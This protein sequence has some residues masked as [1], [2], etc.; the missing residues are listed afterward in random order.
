MNSNHHLLGG[1]VLSVL[2]ASSASAQVTPSEGFSLA[3]SLDLTP[4]C[5]TFP[6]V[7]A[8]PDGSTLIFDGSN[9]SRR[10]ADGTI[11][12]DYGTRPSS[13][14]ASFVRVDE[15]NGLAYIGESSFGTITEL[16]LDTGASRVLTTLGF[17][18]DL[19]FDVVPG[20]AYVTASPN[21]FGLNALYRLDLFSGV[22]TLVAQL[23]GYSGPVL[24]DSV[25]NVTVSV[26]LGQF[27][28]PADS[29]KLIQF[30]G[31]EVT[32]GAIL[33]DE[34]DGDE[35]SVGYD[36]IS[37]AAF[38]ANTGRYTVT[39]VN[40][41]PGGFGSIA[42]ALSD[43]G[44]RQEQIATVPGFA[45]G[46][47]IVDSGAGTALAAYQPPY[48][49]LRLSYSE[50]FSTGASGLYNITP[51][52]A[53]A[54]FTGPASGVTGL[55][56]I[57]VQGGV[58]D[59]YASLWVARSSAWQSVPAIESVGGLYPVALQA[60]AGSFGRRFAPILLNSS[61]AGGLVFTQSPALE[62]AFL[63]QWLIHDPS[64]QIISTSTP[65]INQ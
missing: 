62:G 33:T 46:A 15:A 19:T 44:V 42:W 61:G 20:L 64:L 49:S 54:V 51:R 34:A 29:V 22:T 38:D 8:F 31:V 3:G 32:T 48:T 58:P 13:V 37:S 1:A 2:L 55:A 9:I 25:G 41:G 16:D 5:G 17:N 53:E 50:C 26:D 11:L 65:T 60:S 59:G 35:F 4:L 10:S 39:E 24:V 27:P 28:V 47:Q 23:D 36:G 14:F 52:Q 6:A 43:A 7:H 56:L 63:F 57:D 40:T 45:G 18:Y 30:D 21:G 12:R